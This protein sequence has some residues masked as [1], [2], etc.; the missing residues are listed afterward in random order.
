MKKCC[1]N[2]ADSRKNGYS[3]VYCR[4]FGMPVIRTHEGCYRWNSQIMEVRNAENDNAGV[5]GEVR[6][7]AQG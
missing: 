4:F 7:E 1:G 5:S 2:C 6:R 3:M